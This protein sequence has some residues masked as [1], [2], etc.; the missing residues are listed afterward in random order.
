MTIRRLKGLLSRAGARWCSVGRGHLWGC[1]SSWETTAQGSGGAAALRSCAPAGEASW[2]RQLRKGAAGQT[3][4]TPGGSGVPALRRTGV[5]AR[6]VVR[7][8]SVPRDKRQG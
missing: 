2:P 1:V 8:T 3:A 5:G 4:P 6:R 7:L